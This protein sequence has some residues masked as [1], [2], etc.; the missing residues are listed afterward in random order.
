MFNRLLIAYRVR[1]YVELSQ[2]SQQT[3]LNM[4]RNDLLCNEMGRSLQAAATLGDLGDARAVP[5]LKDA[6]RGAPLC[7]KREVVTSLGRI[8]GEGVARLIRHCLAMDLQMDRN[9]E[10]EQWCAADA[11]QDV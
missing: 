9:E 8:G 10:R 3:T 7:V 11:R 4:L 1:R 5:I 6:L 2:D